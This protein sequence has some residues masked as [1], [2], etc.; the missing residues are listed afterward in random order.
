MET[1]MAEGEW[2]GPSGPLTPGT[3]S[4]QALLALGQLRPQNFRRGNQN[5]VLP[6]IE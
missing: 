5:C 4:R 2:A 6:R 1:Q 3:L